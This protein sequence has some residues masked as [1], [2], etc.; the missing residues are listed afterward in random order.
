MPTKDEI[1]QALARVKDPEIGRSIVELGM[2]KDIQIDDGVVDVTIAL[3]VE[4]CPLQGSI[5]ADVRDALRGLPGVAAVNVNL[6]VMSKE[7]LEALTAR[8]RGPAPES[9]LLE[10][11]SRTRIIAVA[12]GKGGVGKSAVTVNL[13]I[14]LARRGAAVGLLD[15]DILGFSVPRLMGLLGEHPTVLNETLLPIVQFGVKVMSMGFFLESEDQPVI[16]RAPLLRKYF[17]QMITDVHWGDLDYLLLD[18]PPGTGDMTLNV[19][20]LMPRSEMLIVTTPQEAASHVALRAGAMAFRAGM[21]VLG[22]VEN[23]SYFRCPHC[24]EISYLFGR[25]GGDMVAQSLGVPVLGRVPMTEAI[26][27]GSDEGEPVMAVAPQDDAAQA[28]AELAEAIA[29]AEPV[30]PEPAAAE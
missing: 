28:F 26:Q 20:Q 21:G 23:M 17:E 25:G 7:E 24:G 15:A 18:L 1:M 8:L 10:E 4:G 9:P 30:R 22:V 5:G 6:T 27:R 14:A 12:S 13:A 3:T 29:A 2:V 11:D 16:W 19:V